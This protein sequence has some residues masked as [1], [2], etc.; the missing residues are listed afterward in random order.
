MTTRCKFKCDS[1]QVLAPNNGKSPRNAIL[2]PVYSSD[3]TSENKRFWDYTPSGKFELN[4][5]NESVEFVP[6]KEYYIDITL[7]E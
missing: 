7:A 5:I 2:S 1:I 6:G 3:P 4:Y